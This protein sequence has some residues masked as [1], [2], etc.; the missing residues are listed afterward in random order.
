[1]EVQLRGKVY[2]AQT[3]LQ[4]RVVRVK[5]EYHNIII[6]AGRIKTVITRKPTR[7]DNKAVR[8]L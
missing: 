7:P 3:L 4:F 5:K 1:M 2:A 8:P 6:I